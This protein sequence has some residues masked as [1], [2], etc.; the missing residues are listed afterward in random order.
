VDFWLIVVIVFAA[1]L[2]IGFGIVILRGRADA[3][4]G[5]SAP[6][7]SGSTTAA[8]AALG[9][10]QLDAAV[11]KLLAEGQVVPAVK[12][13]REHTGL[14]LRQAMQYAQRLSAGADAANAAPAETTRSSISSDAMAQIQ[15][16][17]AQG[18]KIQAIKLVREHTGLGLK[19]AKDLVDRM[20]DSATVA[21][22]DLPAAG[23]QLPPSS[24]EVMARVRA[25]AAQGKKI[26]AI[27]E[28][29]DHTPGLGLKEAKDI[30]ERL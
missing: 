11:G 15:R 27:K 12:L 30:V 13:I 22:L 14:G 6:G 21:A 1:A 2:V 9:G 29:R 8:A 10:E 28:L 23:P 16:L 17:V 25:L 7:S 4:R 26:N 19:E 3:V 20:A 5:P 18:K 24:D